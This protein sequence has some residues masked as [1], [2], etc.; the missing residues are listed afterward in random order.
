MSEF[1]RNYIG[2][3]AEEENLDTSLL[4]KE[5]SEYVEGRER[6]KYKYQFSSGELF[7]ATE[8]VG[9][10][11]FVILRDGKEIFNF[12]EL[13]PEGF[14]FLTPKYWPN[15][16][17]SDGLEKRQ[18]ESIR[19]KWAC[20]EDAISV[21]KFDSIRDVV[22]LLHE[23]G[24]SKGKIP[25]M[26]R[27]TAHIMGEKK[28]EIELYSQE[29]RSAWAEAL[30]AARKVDRDLGV[31]LFE[32]FY[33]TEDLKEYIYTCLTTHRYLAELQAAGKLDIILNVL[34]LKS[35]N[36][37]SEWLGKLFDKRKLTNK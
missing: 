7:E 34:G 22:A 1:I 8:D 6:L 5:D 37:N 14:K 18:G 15:P 23:I 13:V 32:G 31:D 25:F 2:R 27:Q 20:G 24:H 19:G 30:K 16:V 17:E 4:R 29:E 21:G 36:Q 3:R 35:I 26:E 28:R 33:D 10:A 11:K 12:K 9:E